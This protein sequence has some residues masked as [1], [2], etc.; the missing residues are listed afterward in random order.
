MGW[1]RPRFAHCVVRLENHRP[2]PQK[3]DETSGWQSFTT[4]LIRI[5][6]SGHHLHLPRP[7]SQE[8]F[9]WHS[10]V[11]ILAWAAQRCARAIDAIVPEAATEL[12]SD[13]GH[14]LDELGFSDLFGLPP[15]QTD[16]NGAYRCLRW[17]W[18]KLKGF[19]CFRLRLI[20]FSK[21]HHTPHPEA[22][23]P[24]GRRLHFGAARDLCRPLI[25]LLASGYMLR[26]KSCVHLVAMLRSG[27]LQCGT[28]SLAWWQCAESSTGHKHLLIMRYS[29]NSGRLRLL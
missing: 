18:M 25:F 4:A 20:P 1:L 19:R 9:W 24:S 16:S 11:R 29:Q 17:S 14:Q 8:M 23:L 21:R 22:W 28:G 12:R 5:G 27:R 26:A 3:Q 6:R 2:T 15:S 13:R 10:M 7:F